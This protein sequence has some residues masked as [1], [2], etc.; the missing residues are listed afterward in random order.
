[1]VAAL[2]LAI[3]MAALAQSAPGSD[4]GSPAPTALDA[5]A[6]AVPMAA[7]EMSPRAAVWMIEDFRDADVKFDLNELV[8]NSSRPPP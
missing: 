4:I 8:G 7:P 3:G 6:A 1:M 2:A 5:P